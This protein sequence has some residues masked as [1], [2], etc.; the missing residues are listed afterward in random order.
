MLLGTTNISDDEKYFLTIPK[1]E[2][3]KLINIH[4]YLKLGKIEIKLKGVN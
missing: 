2:Q 1:D 3:H 4:K